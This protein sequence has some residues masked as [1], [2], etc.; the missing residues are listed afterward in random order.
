MERNDAR[1]TARSSAEWLAEGNAHYDAQD[2][3]EAGVALEHSL[4][5]DSRQADAW[6]RLGNVREEQ[7]QD[8]LAAIEQLVPQIHLSKDKAR[9]RHER[10][11]Q[12]SFSDALPIANRRAEIQA[13]IAANQVVIVCGETGSGKTTQL[14]KICLELKRGIYGTI[15]CTQRR[16]RG[17]A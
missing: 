15:A 1:G 11:P 14:P 16:D 10:L 6:Y 8:D 17:L 2:W 12:P 13:A 9:H 3:N 5:L 4:A 7:G